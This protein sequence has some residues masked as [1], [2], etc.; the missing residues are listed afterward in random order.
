MVPYKLH[1]KFG[2]RLL[3]VFLLTEC[4]CAISCKNEVPVE[5]TGQVLD[6]DDLPIVGAEVAVDGTLQAVTDKA[7]HF[8]FRTFLNSKTPHKITISKQDALRYFSEFQNDVSLGSNKRYQTSLRVRL[9][10][11]PKHSA[12][13]PPLDETSDSDSKIRMTQPSA[14]PIILPNEKTQPIQSQMA[15]VRPQNRAQSHAPEMILSTVPTET[16]P[17]ETNFRNIYIRSF[18]KPIHLATARSFDSQTGRFESVCT[19]NHHGKCR[20][21]IPDA[22]VGQSIEVLVSHSTHISKLLTLLV[23]EL[24]PQYVELEPG[25]S[26]TVAATLSS[27]SGTTPAAGVEILVDGTTIGTTPANGLLIHVVPQGTRQP[28]ITMRHSH[29]VPASEGVTLSARESSLL[30]PMFAPR[31]CQRSLTWEMA[32]IADLYD[33][34]PKEIVLAKIERALDIARQSLG[35]AEPLTGESCEPHHVLITLS[36]SEMWGF[37][38]VLKNY[39]QDPDQITIKHAVS[40]PYD[41]SALKSALREAI[42]MALRTRVFNAS[43]SSSQADIFTITHSGATYDFRANQLVDAWMPRPFTKSEPM[44][45]RNSRIADLSPDSLTLK[46]LTSDQSVLPAAGRLVRIRASASNELSGKIAATHSRPA[47]PSS[48]G[49][50]FH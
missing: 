12:I 34:A 37:Q 42:D 10:S 21:A 43:I 39:S 23:S 25:M 8:A 50:K 35:F 20:L 15:T 41:G 29:H 11:M 28:T 33:S 31:T 16:K 47:A 18:G 22:R 36:Q 4:F 24:G 46:T 6:E 32:P 2:S 30:E 1:A 44:L 14:G 48:S 45:V 9:L 26:V 7:G 38:V 19:T 40:P 49:V 3:S 17:P 13:A 27:Q 5:T